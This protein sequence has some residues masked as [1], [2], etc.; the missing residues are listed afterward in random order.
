[1]STLIDTYGRH[2]SYLRLSITELCNFKCMYCLPSGCIKPTSNFLST[3]EI[4][5]LILAFNDLGLKKIRITGGEPTIRKDFLEIGNILSKFKNIAKSLVFT[6]NGYNLSKIAQSSFN[7]GY[8]GVNVSVDSLDEDRFKYITGRNCLKQVLNGI[9]NAVY[10]GLKTKV[11]VVLLKSF[12]KC[13]LEK[14]ILWIKDMPISIRFIELMETQ[15]NQKYFQKNK[16]SSSYIESFLKKN[17][18]FQIKSQ[19]TDGPAIKFKHNDFIGE[20]GLISPYTKT[21]CDTCNRLRVSSI[22]KLHLCL[23]GDI[24]Y[25]L[26]Y[27]LQSSSQKNDLT[28]L[29]KDKLKLK[30]NSHYLHNGDFGIVKQ[31]ASIGG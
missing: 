14:Y 19:K 25:N 29:I 12:S 20:I 2:F 7:A 23:F 9:N 31:L 3:N 13:E 4:Y 5:N 15:N 8:T 10:T 28:L 24:N 11:N 21:F 16:I 1:M 6:T 30:K 26:R 18:W 17:G 22:G 27:L